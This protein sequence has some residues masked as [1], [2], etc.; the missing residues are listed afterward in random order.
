M[1]TRLWVLLF[2]I[3]G[4]VLAQTPASQ[5]VEETH[6]LYRQYFSQKENL[7]SG[8]GFKPWK[9][10]EWFWGQRAFPSGVIPAGAR[11]EA[12]QQM[13]KM[14][15]AHVDDQWEEL[16]PAN[17]GGRTRVIRFHP[18]NPDI[19]FAGSVSGG[20]WKSTD[21]GHVWFPITDYLPNIAVGAF[22]FDPL[23]PDTMYLGT[24]EGT[25]NIDAVLGIGLLKS[26]DG[27]VTWEQTALSWPYSSDG[28]VNKISVDP[29]NPENIIVAT[30]T[31]LRRTTD[32]GVSFSTPFGGVTGDFKDVQRDPQN[33]DTLLA[34]AGNPWGAATNGIYKS[35]DGG[36]TWSRR[37]SGLPPTNSMGRSILAYYESNSAVVYCGISE[38][39][40]AGGMTIGIYRSIDGGEIWAAMN[41]TTE[42]FSEQGWYD[43]MLAVHPTNSALV[44]AAGRYMFRSTNSGSHWSQ[45]GQTVHVDFHEFVFHPNNSSIVFVGTD[46][47]LFMSYNCESNVWEERNTDYVT[48][49]YY[50]FGNATI[51]TNL[52][53][54][55][56]QDNGTT[57]W[58]GA[59][60]W[61][62]VYGGDGGYCVVDWSNDNTVYA[63]WQFGHHV[64]SLNGGN[65]FYP[66][67][68]GIVG[69]GPWV[70]PV[71]QDPFE[72]F[73]LYTTA[74]AG[75]IY[76]TTNRGT[77]WDSLG[78]PIGGEV[79]SIAASPVLPERL[80][81]A[82]GGGVYRK[83]PGSTIWTSASS[84]LPGSYVTRVVAALG[85]PDGVYAT[86]S[87]FGGSHVFW[88]SDAGAHWEN[89]TGDLPNVP[90]QDIAINLNDASTLYVGTD[91][92]V[93]QTTNHGQNWEIFG[94]GFPV[95]VVD[96]MEM[97]ARTGMLRAAT[98]GRGLWQIPTGNPSVSF[99]YPNGSELL[100]VGTPIEMRWAGEDFSGDVSIELNREYPGD[101]WEPLYTSTPNDGA[102]DWTVTEPLT[103][104]ARFRIT[105]LTLPDQNDTT[106]ADT[107]IVEPGLRLSSP[108]GGEA[109]Y[110]TANTYITFERILL[111]D[112]LV[113]ELNR[114]YPSG[115]WESIDEAVIAD[116]EIRWLVRGASSDNAR[117]R[118]T[119]LT[120]PSIGDTSDADFSLVT[121]E[122]TL[123]YPNGGELLYV[124][125]TVSIEWSAP[126]I[127]GRV[128]ISINR[129]YPDGDWTHVYSNT[130]NDGQ[131][132]WTVSEPISENC[133]MRVRAI[134][135]TE[136][137]VISGDDFEIQS[138]STPSLATIP[139]A[140]RV[141]PPA[142]NPFNPET[143]ITFELPSLR[144][145]KIEVFNR[146]GRRVSVLKEETMPAGVHRVTFNGAS[147]SSGIYFIRVQAGSEF[148]IAKVA[149]VR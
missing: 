93:Y 124:D 145:V 85:N 147:L 51:D 64:R 7:G 118:I 17:I 107:R 33:P 123:F 115:E 84:G 5:N 56:A 106:N 61:D 149:L 48:H 78:S 121:P 129:D 97:Q 46:G 74:G 44:F 128:Q 31:G 69:N 142:P 101:T 105:H 16:G 42:I 126:D 35:T 108:N 21:A 19:M 138:L 53:F 52:A 30:R 25:Y 39:F 119:S 98:H 100:A 68:T 137:E 66:I 130:S 13:L 104:H 99:L 135:A 18:N 79:L 75:Q 125:S 95:V 102:A 54:G 87:G 55:G 92:G 49:Q 90:V 109:I 143:V 82:R 148:D 1:R 37:T 120:N 96:D 72:P 26:T 70:T 34:S 29:V 71:I 141:L 111:N 144:Q 24:G 140:F 8:T 28:A 59:R 114:D 27:G 3:P 6:E 133:R 73:T 80:Y 146:L 110:V 62:W 60:D 65:S 81:A 45:V 47:G 94:S 63:E 91:L 88:S 86:I 136:V 11:W 132:N 76:I 83:D 127:E 14:P 139:T 23:H 112:T 10:A 41:T 113:I 89:I 57:R 116:L 12:Y 4:F 122:M 77:Q 117:M 131:Q 50:G 40:S 2:L 38:T 43:M 134:M 67:Q 20:L 15:R 36:A 58:R 32:G 9:R 22:E 103:N